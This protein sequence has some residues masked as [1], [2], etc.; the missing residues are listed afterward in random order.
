MSAFNCVKRAP[1]PRALSPLA[2]PSIHTGCLF[3]SASLSNEHTGQE[4][5]LESSAAFSR[6]HVARNPVMTWCS[7][8]HFH[9][10]FPLSPSALPLLPLKHR[11]RSPPLSG[12]HQH[13]GTRVI[14]STLVHSRQ[15]HH[16]PLLQIPFSLNLL[17]FLHPLSLKLCISGWVYLLLSP[18]FILL[19]VQS[20]RLDK[21]GRMVQQIP[22]A[23]ERKKINRI[24]LFSLFLSYLFS[25]FFPALPFNFPP[26]FAASSP[27]SLSF[28]S[29]STVPSHIKC[30]FWLKSPL[31]LQIRMPCLLMFFFSYISLRAQKQIYFPSISPIHCAVL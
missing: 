2:L 12:I 11:C 14:K 25:S 19:A 13:L 29:H 31:N 22:E 17:L 20:D 23:S 28:E 5:R 3:N 15:W 9:F 1:L 7:L 24:S 6:R 16:S 8:A 26:P 27:S 30:G 4:W 21:C 10:G 18:P